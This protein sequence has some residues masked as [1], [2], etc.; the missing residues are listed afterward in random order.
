MWY[1]YLKYFVYGLLILST[2]FQFVASKLKDSKAKQTLKDM[3]AASDRA[4]Q[5]TEEIAEVCAIAENDRDCNTGAQKLALALRI[6]DERLNLSTEEKE[7]ATR[8]INAFVSASKYVNCGGYNMNQSTLDLVNQLLT[9]MS[10]DELNIMLHD[11]YQDRIP[12]E[13]TVNLIE[14]NAVE[15]NR[16]F[17]AGGIFK[18]IDPETKEAKFYKVK[19]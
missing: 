15:G 16:L 5:I 1:E 13:K 12:S 17:G 8:E 2:V 6:L 4:A 14:I 10:E 11:K 19:E 3:A 9:V 18:T 7:K